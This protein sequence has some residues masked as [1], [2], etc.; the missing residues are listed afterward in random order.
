MSRIVTKSYYRRIIFLLLTLFFLSFILPSLSILRLP[1][2]IPDL[3]PGHH[4]QRKDQDLFDGN[5]WS[6]EVV[7]TW[8]ERAE[9]V[10]AAFVHAYVGYKTY[11][12]GMD[13][14]RPVSNGGVNKCVPRPLSGA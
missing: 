10:K 5:I 11:A 13:E 12:F 2:P 4:G 7:P 14:L 9:K 3:N 6:S 1:I 8:P